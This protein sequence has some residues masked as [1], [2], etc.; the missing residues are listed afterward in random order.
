MTFS[1]DRGELDALLMLGW[2][3]TAKM[4][5]ALDR[6][7]IAFI[8]ALE[9]VLFSS[10]AMLTAISAALGAITVWFHP[11]SN[12]RDEV[13]PA[14]SFVQRHLPEVDHVA[15]EVMGRTRVH[16]FPANVREDPFPVRCPRARA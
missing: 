3:M 2:L 8:T 12:D 1:W 6:R 13:G 16:L 10:A 15:L 14:L 7:P 4:G 9:I 11:L 5:G